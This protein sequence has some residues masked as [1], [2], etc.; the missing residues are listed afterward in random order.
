MI[1]LKPEVMIE[2]FGFT[3]YDTKTGE[4]AKPQDVAKR[5]DLD[6]DGM[7]AIGFC[8]DADGVLY[9]MFDDDSVLLVP[10][11]TGKYLIQI[12]GGKYMRW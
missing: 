4:P 6:L 10:F 3:V 8:L 12:N 5:E 7:T 2:S 1:N 11:N 9:L